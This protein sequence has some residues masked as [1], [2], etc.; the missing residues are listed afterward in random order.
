M[1]IAHRCEAWSVYDNVKFETPF[2]SVVASLF[3][4]DGQDFAQHC[5]VLRLCLAVSCS[6]IFHVGTKALGEGAYH[7]GGMIV[8]AELH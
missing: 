6:S 4:M 7:D 1:C 2:P 3:Q 8:N 5:L